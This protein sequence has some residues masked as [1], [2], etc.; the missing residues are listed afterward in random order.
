[1]YPSLLFSTLRNI[2]RKKIKLVVYTCYFLTSYIKITIFASPRLKE[3]T[4]TRAQV[5]IKAAFHD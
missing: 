3:S 5:T 4:I 2:C 1:M